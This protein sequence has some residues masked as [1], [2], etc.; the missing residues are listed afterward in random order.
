MVFIIYRWRIDMGKSPPPFLTVGSHLMVYTDKKGPDPLLTEKG[1]QQIRKTAQ[2]WEKEI[3]AGIPLPGVLYSSPLRRAIDTV[4]I[5]WNGV[6]PITT[7]RMV[8]PIS[9]LLVRRTD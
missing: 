9:Y 8:C 3:N 2:H 4:E 7:D 1:R 5:T 6:L